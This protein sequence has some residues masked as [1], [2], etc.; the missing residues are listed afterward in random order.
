MKVRRNEGAGGALGLLAL[1]AGLL[2]AAALKARGV[3]PNLTP[4]H[5]VK[6]DFTRLQLD[7]FKGVTAVMD[8]ITNQIKLVNVVDE[9]GA[10]WAKLADRLNE[11]GWM[12]L[13]VK[14]SVSGHY[15]NDLRMYSAGLTEG[16]LTAER[17]SQFYTNFFPL[18]Q[19]DQES[20][21]AVM[22]I[23]NLFS[24]EIEH[25]MGRCM[26]NG[27]TNG[28]E[29]SDPYWKHV[30]YLFI[31]MWGL[32][33]AYNLVAQEKKVRSIDMIDMFFINSHAEL[34]EL[35]QAYKP[36]AV[37]SRTAFQSPILAKAKEAFLQKSAETKHAKAMVEPSPEVMEALDRD[38][39][40]RLAK[41][42]HCSALVRLTPL[43]K[44]LL[45]GHTT[46]SDYSK[47]TRVYKYY[48]F[49]LPMSFVASKLISFS[50]Y[51]G[52]VTSTDDFY[53]LQRGLVV[54]DTSLEILNPQLYDRV[55]EFPKNPR[56]PKFMHVMSINRLAK[57]GAHWTSMYAE[58]NFGT[59]NSQFLVV[60]YNRFIPEKPLQDSVV[61]VVEQV[62]GVS[63]QADVS[64]ELASRGYW[65]SFNRPF[66]KDTRELSG[67]AAA[68]ATYGK[69]YSYESAPR[70]A[71]MGTVSPSITNLADMRKTM[72]RNDVS[73]SVPGT[74]GGTGHAIAARLDLDP[75][76][77]NIPNGGI[78]AKVT[79]RC[80]MKSMK[81]QAVSGPTHDSQPVFRWKSPAVDGGQ[82]AELFPGW[83]HMG[84]P[85]V[86]DFHY[87]QM[88]P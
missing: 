62:P 75:M 10:A 43:N 13:H 53:A 56:I 59:G 2:Q 71:I 41:R 24:H 26:L 1:A 28:G 4:L 34:P 74:V 5:N 83:P 35:I 9:K 76:V 7:E 17:V 52:C 29:P 58:S 37:K 25:I 50:S 3:H 49:D 86:W 33:D 48:D 46:W 18:L 14:T 61:R 87:M 72:M 85:D 69:F 68:E 21:M 32:K 36:S 31:Q 22:N 27:G 42:G 70:A 77:S 65:G 67:H 20:T 40:L 81:V 12:E 55:P 64:T 44:D 38:W 16:I 60:D 8:N 82:A 45:A 19:P 84:L 23:R 66:F 57:S 47:M 11:T 51:P 63:Q 54:M 73:D 88:G 79:S 15:S 30:R 6:A 78:D 39:K 80:L